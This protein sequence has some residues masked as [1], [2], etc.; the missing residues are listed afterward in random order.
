MK[1]HICLL[2]VFAAPWIA[3]ALVEAQAP[4]APAPRSPVVIGKIDGGKA[5]SPTYA[6]K[7]AQPQSRVKEWFR[8][9]VEYDTEADWTDELN[10]TFY[11]VVKGKT[12]DAPPFTLFKSETSYLHIPKGRKHVADMYLHPNIVERF[13]DVERVAVEIR[14]AGRVLDR[15]GKPQLTSAW[16][17]QL[18]P[19]EG[20]LLNRAQT[21]FAF[22]DIDDQEIIK[23][24]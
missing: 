23:P 17:E 7:G 19:V 9:F 16:W 12:K 2:A 14:A 3:P 18:S 24:K 21:P 10:F 15:A 1:S 13:G 22:V 20:V 8:V 5:P 11:V 4:A 6:V